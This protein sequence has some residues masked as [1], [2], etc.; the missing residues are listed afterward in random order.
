MPENCSMS[1]LQV[2]VI[3]NM[4][5]ITFELFILSIS[6]SRPPQ[7]LIP[8]LYSYPIPQR[9][10]SSSKVLISKILC[11]LWSL[12]SQFYMMEPLA[13]GQIRIKT[14]Q[15]RND[16]IIE[17]QILVIKTKL[18]WDAQCQILSGCDSNVS[19]LTVLLY[20]FL[21]AERLRLGSYN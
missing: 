19:L 4:Q 1:N 9:S 18:I 14:N 21:W 16:V 10:D 15:R 12:S 17:Q 11:R 2:I 6:I 5:R 7:S 8:P 20:L 13:P 3:Q